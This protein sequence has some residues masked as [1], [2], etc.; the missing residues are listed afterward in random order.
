M[1]P[2]A[3]LYFLSIRKL[4]TSL[5][6]GT[7]FSVWS[8]GQNGLFLKITICLSKQENFSLNSFDNK[9][10]IYYFLKSFR[11]LNFI[12]LPALQSF[13][14]RAT[15]FKK[16]GLNMPKTAANLSNFPASNSTV[17]LNGFYLALLLY[18]MK[19]CF[20]LY[21]YLFSPLSYQ[22]IS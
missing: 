2:Y 1:R 3:T 18:L 11:D 22:K 5:G 21:L 20:Y 8:E 16:S 19:P 10:S 14:A 7:N 6:F 17:F 4:H 15:L 9:I 12:T 13:S